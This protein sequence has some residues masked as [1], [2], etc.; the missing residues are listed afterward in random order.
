[1]ESLLQVESEVNRSCQVVVLVH[2]L[3]KWDLL[4]DP[5]LL[6]WVC[7]ANAR[8]YKTRACRILNVG[9]RTENE[10]ENE[11]GIIVQ[12]AS[13]ISIIK[14]RSHQKYGN[15][16][17][18]GTSVNSTLESKA[19]D[20]LHFSLAEDAVAPGYF[21]DLGN[22]NHSWI[23]LWVVQSDHRL[24]LEGEIQAGIQYYLK[25]PCVEWDTL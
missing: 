4:V 22:E 20:H 14:S 3:V 8:K 10:N 2:Q 15:L 21:P 11:H 19:T 5:L 18:C 6:T 13:K 9:K 17:T 1:M 7:D 25:E 16:K 12:E 23:T 24:G